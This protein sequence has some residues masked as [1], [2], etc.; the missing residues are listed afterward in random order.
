MDP[1]TA[2]A[3]P[4]EADRPAATDPDLIGDL[5]DPVTGVLPAAEPGDLPQMPL[6]LAQCGTGGFGW[7]ETGDV[8]RYRA[9]LGAARDLA[10]AAGPR[11]LWPLDG[12]DPSEATAHLACVGEDTA[13]MLCDGVNRLLAD[14][15]SDPAQ[16]ERRFG[17]AERETGDLTLEVRHPLLAPELSVAAVSDG[18]RRLA[19]YAHPDGRTAREVALRHAGAVAQSG[20][21]RDP[22]PVVATPPGAPRAAEAETWDAAGALAK[23]C[24]EGE[25]PLAARGCAEPAFDLLGAVG[26]IGLGR[27]G[28]AR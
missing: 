11:R 27:T 13:A 5:C 12:G 22:V 10:A 3:E 15:L 24:E 7:G 26:W 9:A 8:A 2:V 28:G 14:Q 21:D 23:L 20:E 4:L 6:A 18:E 16:R 17:P 25:R 1:G 19:V